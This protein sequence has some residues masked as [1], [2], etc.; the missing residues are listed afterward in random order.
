MLMVLLD[1]SSFFFQYSR[2]SQFAF[3]TE[4]KVGARKLTWYP[5]ITLKVSFSRIP[6]EVFQ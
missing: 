3:L 5:W 4:K 1:E 6:F 2:V